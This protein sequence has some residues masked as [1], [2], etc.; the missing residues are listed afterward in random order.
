MNRVKQV[1][2]T[3]KQV[4]DFRTFLK[5]YVKGVIIEYIFWDRTNKQYVIF[6]LEPER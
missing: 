3:K 5:Q 4:N 2:P 1:F 6:W